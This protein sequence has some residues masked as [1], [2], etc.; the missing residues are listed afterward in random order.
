MV[1]DLGFTFVRRGAL[2]AAA[3]VAGGLD[4]NGAPPLAPVE[5]GV[6]LHYAIAPRVALLT[7]DHELSFGLGGDTHP[8]ALSI[9]VGVG[10]QASARIYAQLETRL[11]R[12]GLLHAMGN[13]YL[14]ADETPL[15]ASVFVSPS[16]AVDLFAAA[17]FDDLAHAGDAVALAGGARLFF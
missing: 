7:G 9:P 16:H 10:V 6:N 3:H 8:I 1:A 14:F 12:F 2:T 17:S 4:Q 11:A 15:T 13:E 5:L